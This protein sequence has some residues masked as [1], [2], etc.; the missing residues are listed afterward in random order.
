M[1]QDVQI[2][3]ALIDKYNNYAQGLDSKDWPLVRA[4]FADEVLIDYGSMSDPT[5]DPAIPSPT[6]G[7][8]FRVR[9]S[10]AARISSPTM[11]YSPMQSGPSSGLRMS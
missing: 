6:T 8:P 4:C 5:S 1:Q 11:P 2:R 3:N 9:K 7:L 10:V